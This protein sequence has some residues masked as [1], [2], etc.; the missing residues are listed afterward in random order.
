MKPKKHRSYSFRVRLNKKSPGR[1]RRFICIPFQFAERHFRIL[2]RQ[3]QGAPGAVLSTSTPL[4][5]TCWG[6]W[7]GGAGGWRPTSHLLIPTPGPRAKQE[8]QRPSRAT[9]GHSAGRECEC[10]T[11][12]LSPL[13]YFYREEPAPARLAQGAGAHTPGLPAQC[14]CARRE[15]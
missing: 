8:R 15:R 13:G 10:E 9:P 1:R 2:S 11:Q 14:A 7:G 4:P 12:A 3:R 6:G 5:G